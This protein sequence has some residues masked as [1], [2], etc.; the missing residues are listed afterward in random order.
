MPNQTFDSFKTEWLTDVLKNNPNSVEKGNRF[1]YKLITQ[2]LD[3]PDDAAEV[4]GRPGQPGLVQGNAP[5]PDEPEIFYCDGAG[6]GG[7]DLAC[8]ITGEKDDDAADAGGSV[9][10]KAPTTWY[11]V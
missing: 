8:K 4:R 10:Q 5:D 11:V 3:L 2:W 9:S 6:D 7:I 1:S